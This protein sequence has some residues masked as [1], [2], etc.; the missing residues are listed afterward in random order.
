MKTN[1]GNKLRVIM[2]GP[3]RNVHGGVSTMVNNYYDAGLDE[4]I[5]LT[6]IST[7]VDGSILLKLLCA[8]WA[9]LRFLAYLPRMNILHANM[10]SNASYYR[11][12]IFVDTAAVFKKKI[13]IYFRGGDFQ[14]FYH[15]KSIQSQG[16]IRRTLGK[17]NTFIVLSQEWK[18]VFIPLIDSNKIVVL[19]N[20]VP[21]PKT[22]KQD[23]S[24]HKIL[25][26]GRL[27][28]EKGISELLDIM[29]RL[30]ELFPNLHLYLGG[31][32][33]DKEMEQKAKQMTDMVTYLGWIDKETQDKY[34]ELCSIFVLPTYFEGQPN[35]LIE[36]MAFGMASV[37]TAVGGIPQLIQND[38]NGRLIKPKDKEDL[39][40]A[41]AELLRDENLRRRYGEAAFRFIEKNYN[42]DNLVG[43]LCQIYEQV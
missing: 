1:T 10:S 18:E 25:F 13:I 14:T 9:Y 5:N 26:L 35:S 23:Y 22:T 7:M 43:R 6:Y 15:Q 12:K 8:V 19:G 4:R 40:K 34:K 16:R 11:K 24:S 31:T 28:R 2:I 30:K 42:I 17:A 38:V 21:M 3:A 41:L 33:S 36:A 39:F 37:A 32:W 29:P 27:C 20:A